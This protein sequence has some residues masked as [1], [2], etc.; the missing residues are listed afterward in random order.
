MEAAIVRKTLARDE[1]DINDLV[2]SIG[3]PAF[4]DEMLALLEGEIEVAA[5][6]VLVF[7]DKGFVPLSTASN[8][9]AGRSAFRSVR[10]DA[11]LTLHIDPTLATA[12]VP[13]AASYRQILLRAAEGRGDVALSIEAAGDFDRDDVERVG[14]WAKLLLSLT[15]KHADTLIRQERM[16]HAITNLDEIV[17][18]IAA[19]P[20]QL[21]PREAQVCARILYGQTT[22]GIALELGIGNESVMTYR[23]RAYRRLHIASHRELLCWYLT[24]RA[25][26]TLGAPRLAAASAERLAS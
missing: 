15:W 21:S 1:G 8:T 5:C 6:A 7:R 18:H 16:A 9:P 4:A 23:K 3:T 13:G 17:H 11:G 10:V 24:L 19:S 25:R 14:A 12:A 20:E 26:E 2:L 22:T